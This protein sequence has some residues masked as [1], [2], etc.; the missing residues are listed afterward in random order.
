MADPTGTKYATLDRDL[1]VYLPSGTPFPVMND[2]EAEYLQ[3]LIAGYVE[4]RFEHVSD[5]AELDRL[6]GQELMSFR[7]N[8]WLA[9]GETYDG[10]KLDSRLESKVKDISVEVRQIKTKL[11]ID[12]VAR[13]RARGEGSLAHRFSALLRRARRF[14]LHR[15]QQVERALELQNELISLVQ[16]HRNTRDHPEEMKEMHVSPDEILEWVW[17]VLKPEYEAIDEHFREHEQ[18]MWHMDDARLEGLVA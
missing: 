5:L 4:M 2:D 16:L 3:R 9:L 14:E 10:A 6:V 18:Q 7:Y 12:K 11:G 1:I 17:T 8:T 15:C 13:E